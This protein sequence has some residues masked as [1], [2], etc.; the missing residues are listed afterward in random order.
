VELLVASAIFATLALLTFMIITTV[1]GSWTDMRSRSDAYRRLD[2]LSFALIDDLRAV[3][4]DDL[5]LIG[6]TATTRFFAFADPDGNHVLA[7]TRSFGMGHERASYITGGTGGEGFGYPS[8]KHPDGLAEVV[9]FSRNG[10]L[11]RSLRAPPAGT[12]Q[13]ITNT[14]RAQ[15]VAPGVLRFSLRFWGPDTR[16]WELSAAEQGRRVSAIRLPLAVWDSTRAAGGVFDVFPYAAG[17]ESSVNTADD[18]FP[19]MAEVNVVLDGG[20]ARTAILRRDLGVTDNVLYTSPTAGIPAPDVYPYLYI[21]GE[22]VRYSAKERNAFIVERGV[23]GSK[24]VP[25]NAGA[26][27]RWGYP[28]AFRVYIPAGKDAYDTGIAAGGRR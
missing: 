1:T 7:F 24:A 18:V 23:L 21:D 28:A 22:W 3:N 19:R 12:F 10:N 6:N 14:S 2:I 20:S 13:D 17:P 26:K 25:H 15:L 27:V 9:Y 8:L 5:R 16:A 11:Y 4:S